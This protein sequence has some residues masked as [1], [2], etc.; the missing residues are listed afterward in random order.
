MLKKV[1]SYLLS[2]IA[3][4][5][6][7]YLGYSYFKPFTLVVDDNNSVAD[8]SQP[9]QVVTFSGNKDEA[10]LG[11]NAQSYTKQFVASEGFADLVDFVAPAVVTIVATKIAPSG[12]D[13]ILDTLDPTFK[14]FYKNLIP[15]QPESQLQK[16]TSLGSGFIIRSDGFI[17]TNNH[18]VQGAEQVKVNL[19]DGRQYNG[20]VYAKDELTDLAIIKIDA[21][22]LLSLKF[23]NSDIIRVGEWVLAIGN[24]LGLGGTVSS[25]IISAIGRDIN[26]GPYNDFLQ[27]DAP[28]NRGNSGG[29][30]INTKGE[31]V[32]V[33]TAILSTSENGGSIGIGFAV[34]SNVVKNIVSQLITNKK[35]LRSWLGVQIQPVDETIAKS[36]NLA[37]TQGALISNIIPGS[38]ASKSALQVGDVIIAVNDTVLKNSR[39]L[40]KIISN[41]L[42]GSIV[43]LTIISNKVQ[44]E[45]K[46]ELTAI[47]DSILASNEVI[48][49]QKAPILGKVKEAT[50]NSLAIK[51]AEI[52]D[53]VRKYFDLKQ[54]TKGVIVLS[55]KSGSI[56]QQKGLIAGLIIVSVNQSA[57]N[58][59]NDLNALIE[60]N[61]KS[62]VVLLVEDLSKKQIFI[63]MSA[64]EIETG[65]V[66]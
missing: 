5:L 62:G 2:I 35:V 38:P 56:A 50:I 30:L 65:F 23:A 37:T 64:K 46:V 54:N 25:G 51:V 21:Q 8:F 26:M 24:P 27:T 17:V 43:K 29:P 28:I 59:I 20:T 16:L 7:A 31:V 55:V 19:K 14:E 33:N 57:V 53:N 66:D 41:L 32:G 49:T 52:D 40:P 9:Q 47:P 10:K 48:P 42:P 44:K 63:S 4:L 15:Q 12:S 13:P 45:I 22:D 61:K 34:P 6:I 11:D 18:V 60:K 39:L 36:F 58:S 3:L 1:F